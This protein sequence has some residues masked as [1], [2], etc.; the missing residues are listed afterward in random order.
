M[1]KPKAASLLWR[2]LDWMSRKGGRDRRRTR[3]YPCNLDGSPCLTATLE[4]GEAQQVRVRNISGGGV[5][6][7]FERFIEPQSVLMVKLSNEAQNFSCRLKIR[8]AYSL[9]HPNGEWIVGGAFTRKLTEHELRALLSQPQS[10]SVPVLKSQS[11]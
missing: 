4:G 7:V 8:V 11:K 9:E 6:L 2:W 1:A 5:S 3:R 10:A